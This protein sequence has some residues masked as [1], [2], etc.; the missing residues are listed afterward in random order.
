MK[1]K[2][3]FCSFSEAIREGAKLRPQLFG[4]SYPSQFEARGTCAIGAGIEASYGYK[5]LDDSFAGNLSWELFPY[6]ASTGG[7]PVPACNVR[8]NWCSLYF[9]IVHLN[10]SHE[11]T[12]EAIADWLETEEEKLGYVTLT[13][14]SEALEL[15]EFVTVG[16]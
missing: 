12:R 15:S 5:A 1:I 4:Y 14:E 3:H 2:K 16:R 6:L 7:C 13:E 8:G 10:D 9:T 11:W